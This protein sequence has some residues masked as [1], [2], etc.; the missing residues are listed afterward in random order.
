[1]PYGVC[2]AGVLRGACSGGSMNVD[3]I[4]V[5]TRL[6]SGATRRRVVAGLFGGALWS[7]LGLAPTDA[8][9]KGKKG[10]KRGKKAKKKDPECFG[11]TDCPV[12]HL[13]QDG[14][15]V[16]GCRVHDHCNEYAYTTN[17]CENG[18]CKPGCTDWT[19]PLDS[20]CAYAGHPQQG[21]CVAGCITTADCQPYYYCNAGTCEPP[22]CMNNDDC[23]AGQTCNVFFRCW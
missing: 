7:A 1:M 22:Q 3:R 16:T 4:V 14:Q 9:K 13:C 19:C 20:Y 17:Y 2:D 18:T 23:P 5:V 21:R 10:K 6:T 8:G 12:G 15:C 11:A